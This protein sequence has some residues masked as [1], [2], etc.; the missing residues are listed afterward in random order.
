MKC[1]LAIFIFFST[2]FDPWIDMFRSDDVMASSQAHHVTGH[3]EPVS[4][5]SGEFACHTHKSGPYTDGG[6]LECHICHF[7]HCGVLIPT[8]SI[9]SATVFAFLEFIY[10][11]QISNIYLEGWYRP[12]RV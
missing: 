9:G 12:P 5:A 1:L 11:K 4:L 7:G 3:E 2:A 10:V 6:C 8:S